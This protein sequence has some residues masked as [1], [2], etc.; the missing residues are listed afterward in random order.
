MSV[1]STHPSLDV[2]PSLPWSREAERN[3][4]GAVLVDNSCIGV[5]ET[6]RPEDFFLPQNRLIAR[7]ILSLHGKGTPADLVTVAEGL[8]G[9][10][11][12][13][14]AGGA[15]YVGSLSD[16]VPCV[17]NVE[18]YAL[19]VRERAALRA[20]AHGAEALRLAAL[21]PEEGLEG[22]GRRI[23]DLSESFSRSP[24][25]RLRAVSF[26]ELLQMEVPPREMIL[27]P[28][29]PTQGL[30]MLYSKRGLGK[31]YLALSIAYAV[32]SGEA[33]LK[34]KATKPRPVLFVDGELPLAT[35][36]ERLA[37]VTE[38]LA[39]MVE[40]G[41][42]RFITPDLQ[43]RPIPDLTTRE[44]QALIEAELGDAELLILDNLSALCRTG[45]EN[46]G[47]SWLPVQEWALR[48]RQRGV[49]VLF[50]HHAGKGGAQRGTSRRE[51]LL[52]LV[53]NL[54]HPSDY[55]PSD[56]LRCEVHFEKCRGFF[57]EDAKPF[58][59][60]LQAG[61]SGGTVWT[62]RGLEDA[63]EARAAVLYAEGLRVREVA[64]ELGV[65]K[66]Q[67]GRLRKKCGFDESEQ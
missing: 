31:T 40:P 53:V 62:M 43:D 21:D 15:A 44:G 11:L 45:K 42:L 1:L 56:G 2:D 33:F 6:A 61:V 66:S 14:E 9:T 25:Y 39:E 34:W 35:L 54:R 64:E 26:E 55:A 57:G 47:E 10:G 28:I 41:M 30:G 23:V 63:L 52:D 49:S 3:I 59:V 17:S 22:I 13:D 58:E 29:L 27:A 16:D 7:A 67:A 18:H 50:V 46:E 8:L 51:D 37:S 24:R 38:G 4:L 60:G 48:L 65:S 19:I 32:A 12:L 5:F 36:K 20:V